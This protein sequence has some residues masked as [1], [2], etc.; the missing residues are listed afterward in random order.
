MRVRDLM[1]TLLF[2]LVAPPALGDTPAPPA[3][4]APELNLTTLEAE[5]PQGTYHAERIAPAHV[6]EVDDGLFIA[7]VYDR[8][9]GL[10]QEVRGYICDGEDISQ[11]LVGEI[12]ASGSGT[13]IPG[14]WIPAEDP[15]VTVQLAV[16]DELSGAVRIG[17]GEATSLALAEATGDAGLYR[18]EETFDVAEQVAGWIVLADGRQVGGECVPRCARNPRT[19]DRICFCVRRN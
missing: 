16:Q 1:P 2:L 18:S 7:I 8:D 15:D 14:G 13:L 17:D 5:A 3:S 11:W 6:G 9:A 4:P 10:P 12:D 19:G